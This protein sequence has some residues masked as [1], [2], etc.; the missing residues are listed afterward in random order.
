M[1]AMP[2]MPSG[3]RVEARPGAALQPTPAIGLLTVQPSEVQLTATS[4]PWLAR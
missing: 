2:A 3:S 4:K 1:P